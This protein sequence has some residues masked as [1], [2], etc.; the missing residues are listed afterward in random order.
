MQT[1]T[2]T[3]SIISLHLQDVITLVFRPGRFKRS[4]ARNDGIVHAVEVV[5]NY[6]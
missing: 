6:I 3:L 1:H 2:R 4:K 5:D